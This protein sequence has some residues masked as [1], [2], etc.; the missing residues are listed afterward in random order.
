VYVRSTGLVEAFPVLA[1]LEP[2][3]VSDFVAPPEGGSFVVTEAGAGDATCVTT[4]DHFIANLTATSPEQGLTYTAVLHDD[5]FSGRSSAFDLW[6]TPDPGQDSANAMPAADPDATLAVVTA[7]AVTE[8]DFGLRLGGDDVDGCV[9]PVGGD[10]VLIGGNQTPA[11]ALDATRSFTL[12]DQ[13]DQDCSAAP[14][15]GPFELSGSPGSRSHVILMGS[16]GA[17]E[18]IVLPM[19]DGD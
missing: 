18:A 6:E 11:F 9:S 19:I 15:G 2:G 3:A 8:A 1:G 5:P 16:P 12:H 13:P 7:I 17:L 14:V 10:N 4:C